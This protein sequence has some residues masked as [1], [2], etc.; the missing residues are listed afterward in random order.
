VISGQQLPN[1]ND[2]K[3]KDIVDPYVKI[4]IEGCSVDKQSQE[5]SHVSNNGYNPQWKDEFCSFYINYPSLAF[6]TFIIMDKDSV[7]NDDEVGR[8]SIPVESLASGYRHICLESFSGEQM[9][10]SSIF[11]HIKIEKL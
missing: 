1:A 10:P 11:V 6:M 5:T 3:D 2:S 8:Y 7:G 9:S 4:N